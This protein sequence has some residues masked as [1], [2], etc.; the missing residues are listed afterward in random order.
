MRNGW[1]HRTMIRAVLMAGWVLPPAAA[2]AGAA[3][4]PVSIEACVWGRTPDGRTVHLYTLK[5]GRG[6]T[7]RVTDFGCIIVALTAP[8]REGTYADVV[9]GYDRLEDY[10]ADRRHFGA[11][12]GRYGNRIAGG[13]FTLDGQEYALSVNRP[14]N[15]LHGGVRGF[16]KVVWESEAVIRK[17]AAGVKLRYLSRDGEEGYPGN[18]DA[19]VCYWLTESDELRIE[20]TATTDRPT[21][22]NLTNH[23]YFN[24]AGAGRGDILG[25]ELMLAAGHFTPV[26]EGLI[27]TGELRPV[28]GT[29]FDFTAATAIGARIEAADE[30]LRRGGG[31]DHNFVF[32]RWDGK[33]RPVASLYDPGS[34]RRM[35]VLTTEPG[36]QFYS[37]NFLDGSDVGKGGQAYG[38]RCG[39]CLE[40]QHFP[41]SPNKPQFPSCILRPDEEYRHVT[42]FRF[43]AR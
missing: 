34:G 24:L 23:S 28:A 17:G 20:Y 29:P 42:V 4:M 2:G 25:H 3:E 11:V 39:L 18:L 27:P 40:T 6:M 41:D 10:I 16:E 7:M 36:V 33:L 5:N 1:Q 26:D 35:E 38:R 37:G 19:T 13:K 15:H 21:P 43:S 12:V 22:V 14:P 8:D 31:Y 32:S 9:L 30:Q